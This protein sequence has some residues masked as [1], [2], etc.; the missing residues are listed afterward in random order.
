MSVVLK[1]SV[2]QGAELQSKDFSGTSDP[3]VVVSI[4]PND[5]LIKLPQLFSK[6]SEQKTRVIYKNL[7]PEWNEEFVFENV[8]PKDVIRFSVFDKNKLMMDVAMGCVEKTVQDFL[9]MKKNS[10]DPFWVDLEQTKFGKIKINVTL[11]GDGKNSASSSPSTPV[12]SS[13]GVNQTKSN[14]NAGTSTEETVDAHVD[15]FKKQ[16]ADVERRILGELNENINKFEEIS[17]KYASE[18]NVKQLEGIAKQ[19]RDQITVTNNISQKIQ[20]SIQEITLETEGIKQTMGDN[21]VTRLREQQQQKLVSLFMQHVDRFY[22]CQE[23][24]KRDKVDR[25]KRQYK[26]IA[27]C[28]PKGTVQEFTEQ[29]IEQMA[30][31]DKLQFQDLISNHFHLTQSQEQTLDVELKLA[32]ETHED[33]KQLYHSML[34]LNQLFQDFALLVEQQDELLDTIEFNV[35]SAKESVINGVKNIKDSN[36][37]RQYMSPLGLMRKVT[38]L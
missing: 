6:V 26:I 21:A 27:K 11:S 33:I 23:K 38:G 16:V 25:V 4:N 12:S 24:C 1:V 10:Q 28:N 14:T 13:P 32:Q 2:I 7:E 9:N 29:E 31:E 8:T 34:Q 36:K 5:S 17:Q 15:K 3:Y 18:P 37:L 30:L 35:A 22:E 19:V 20:Q